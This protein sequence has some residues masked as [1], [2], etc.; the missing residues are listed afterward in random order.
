MAA[1]AVSMALAER[2]RCQDS[3]LPRDRQLAGLEVRGFAIDS[4]QRQLCVTISAWQLPYSITDRCAH[5]SYIPMLGRLLPQFRADVLHLHSYLPLCYVPSTGIAGAVRSAAA[6][7]IA[8]LLHTLAGAD[9]LAVSTPALFTRHRMPHTSHF[10]VTCC[11][12]H[13]LTASH[14]SLLCRHSRRSQSGAALPARLCW[15]RCGASAT[16]QGS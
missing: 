2:S 15:A 10:V 13:Q 16:A 8:G 9:H 12:A 4:R 5:R 3:P 1:T 14:A 11:T 7:F 6:G